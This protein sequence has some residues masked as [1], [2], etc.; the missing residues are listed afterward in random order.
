MG[1]L[2]RGVSFL[3]DRIISGETTAVL[4]AV[5]SDK[6]LHSNAEQNEVSL[7]TRNSNS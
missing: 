3:H 6:Q 2:G 5:A 7:K 4:R 1:E